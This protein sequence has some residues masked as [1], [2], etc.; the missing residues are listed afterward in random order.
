M[1]KNLLE[2]LYGP[3]TAHTSPQQVGEAVL[4]LFEDAASEEKDQL[5]ANKKPLTAA[6]KSFGISN[7][8]KSCDQWC[9]IICDD[10]AQYREYMALLSDADNMHKLA[11]LGWVAAKCGDQAM[12]NEKPEMKIGFI[13]LSM[14]GDASTKEDGG[15]LET[16]LKKAQEF[17]TTPLDRDDE[18]N[19]VENDDKSSDDN[20]KGIGKPKDGSDPKG[21]PKGT[22]EGLAI[23]RA[24]RRWQQES[25]KG[26]APAELA[27]RVLGEKH[28][29]EMTGCAA[30]PAVEAPLGVPARNRFRKKQQKNDDEQGKPNRQ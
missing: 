28:L 10:E 22:S 8:V 18:L 3:V 21:K 16:I 26:I 29:H 19:P 6:L 25:K 4:K 15:S 24:L 9:E 11:E 20:Q 1:R 2:F 5:V 12:S 27:D 23:K 13:E 14:L 7:E 17:A 30:I